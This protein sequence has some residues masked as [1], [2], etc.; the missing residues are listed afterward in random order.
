MLAS[1]LLGPVAANRMEI[2]GTD[3]SREVVNRARE[4]LFSQFE[5]QRGLP[6]RALMAHFAQEGQGWRLKPALRG[7]VRFQEANLLADCAGLGRFDVIFC[8]NVLIY[9][10]PPTKRAVVDRVLTRL[11]PGGLFFIGTAEGR[12][13]CETP[14]QTL[15]PG[16]FRKAVS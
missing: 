7:M 1:D 13:P 5:V 6:I 10:D 14:L 11:R 9:F 16:A 8:R 4:A 3:I 12:V 2:V 15:G